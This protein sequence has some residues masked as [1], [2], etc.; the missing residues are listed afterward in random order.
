MYIE[1]CSKYMSNKHILI[2]IYTEFEI[3]NILYRM[4]LYNRYVLYYPKDKQKLFY[5]INKILNR[6]RYPNTSNY[7]FYMN[8]L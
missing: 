8:A 1:K 5:T 3:N 2:Q 6:R 4:D 7:M